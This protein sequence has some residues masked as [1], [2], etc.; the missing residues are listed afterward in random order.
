M[1]TAD[2]TALSTTFVNEKWRS[3]GVE[4]IGCDDNRQSLWCGQD[5][6]HA[7]KGLHLRSFDGAEIESTAAF[8]RQRELRLL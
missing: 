8:T 5:D 4:M 6:A 2:G 1:A 3:G 7:T